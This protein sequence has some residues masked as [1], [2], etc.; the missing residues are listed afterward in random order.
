MRNGSPIAKLIAL[1]LV[2]RRTVRVLA[3]AVFAALAP[4]VSQAAT[5]TVTSGADSGPNSLRAA[6]AAANP[7]D[8]IVFNLPLPVLIELTSGELV[9]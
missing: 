9:I 5:I 3:I 4:L 1:S 8:T 6:I 7:G 2:S